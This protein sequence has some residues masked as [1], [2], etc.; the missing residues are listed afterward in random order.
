MMILLALQDKSVSFHFANIFDLDELDLFEFICVICRR[1]KTEMKT[2]CGR[3]ILIKVSVRLI[4]NLIIMKT[5]F[6]SIKIII[7]MIIMCKKNAEKQTN[8]FFQWNFEVRNNATSE[9]HRLHVFTLAR[10]KLPCSALSF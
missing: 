4:L 2:Q 6:A 7:L 9:A 1:S 3:W 5:W 8:K 10:A